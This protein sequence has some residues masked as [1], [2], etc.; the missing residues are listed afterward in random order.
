MLQSLVLVDPLLFPPGPRP[1]FLESI[2]ESL[3]R[4]EPLDVALSDVVRRLGFERF[5][6][7]TS[8]VPTPTR[9]SR[10]Y[11]WTDLPDEWVQRYDRQAY[12]EVDPRVTEAIC[13]AM[14]IAWDRFTFP[15][16]KK[17]R[18]FFDDAA[19]YG[20]CSGVAVGLRDSAR[21]LSGFYLS[22]SRP[23]L[24][25]DARNAYAERQ[26]DILLLA[27]YVH[28]LLT[29]NVVDHHLPPPSLGGR[30]T[31]RERE[32]LQ[33]A[34]KGLSSSQI[35]ATLEVAERTVHYHFANILAK[36]DAANRREAIAKAV[37]AGLVTA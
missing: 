35:G 10:T 37:S 23:R 31:T 13:W 16:T 3:T 28:A 19:R 36:L 9:E 1:R 27:H 8:S 15:E 25:D 12:I 4:R 18:E 14:P 17:R 32:C 24:D 22:S 34:A 6:Y 21:A 7:G 26:G 11:V 29:A 33:L 30:L 20:V 5:T 2:A